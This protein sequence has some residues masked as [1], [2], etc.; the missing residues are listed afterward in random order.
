VVAREPEMAL[1][2]FEVGDLDVLGHE[3]LDVGEQCRWR[4]AV[5]GWEGF[6]VGDEGWVVP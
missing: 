3:V 2:G 1:E 4:L 5:L 6:A